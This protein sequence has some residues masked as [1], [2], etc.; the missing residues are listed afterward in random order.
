VMSKP[1]LY[2]LHMLPTRYSY[3][4][5]KYRLGTYLRSWN[6]TG[7]VMCTK[8]EAP[9]LFNYDYERYC[10]CNYVKAARIQLKSPNTPT[11]P[12][13]KLEIEQ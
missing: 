7:K 1:G 11:D 8:M 3:R 13:P 5:F 2:S 6:D 4:I 9:S 10:M 12:K